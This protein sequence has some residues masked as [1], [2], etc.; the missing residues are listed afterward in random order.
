MSFSSVLSLSIMG[1]LVGRVGVSHF[2]VNDRSTGRNCGGKVN[3]DPG[4]PERAIV[5]QNKAFAAGLKGRGE[6]FWGR[7]AHFDCLSNGNAGCCDKP[8]V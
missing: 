6:G 8:V 2:R 4:K 3:Y 1:F 5:L 7:A